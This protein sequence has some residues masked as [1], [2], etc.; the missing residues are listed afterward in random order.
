MI[1][2]PRSFVFELA[3]QV[4]GDFIGGTAFKVLV[5]SKMI[6]NGVRSHRL[7]LESGSMPMFADSQ[8][9]GQ[10]KKK[11]RSKNDRQGYK[12]RC[13]DVWVVFIIQIQFIVN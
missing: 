6:Q 12:D 11:E 2:L 10:K 1:D 13:N 3:A 7:Y 9:D 4:I 5:T 8:T